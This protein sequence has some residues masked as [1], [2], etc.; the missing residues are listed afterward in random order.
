[1]YVSIHDSTRLDMS[2]IH[3]LAMATR[4]MHYIATYYLIKNYIAVGFI[5]LTSMYVA[6]F[7]L[8]ALNH[9]SYS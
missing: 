5:F 3:T 8:L 9:D 6:N 1:M 4:F 2:V 7:E